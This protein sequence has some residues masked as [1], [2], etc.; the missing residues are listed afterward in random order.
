MADDPET[1]V[2]N[3]H[4]R[5]MVEARHTWDRVARR[6]FAQ[7]MICTT[8]RRAPEAFLRHWTITQRYQNVEAQNYR[9]MA[10]NENGEAF[11]IGFDQWWWQTHTW[12]ELNRHQGP[13]LHTRWIADTVE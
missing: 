13:N 5:M 8:H 2:T 4:Q 12:L 11:Q 1:I 3:E 6:A 9:R 10:V 7:T